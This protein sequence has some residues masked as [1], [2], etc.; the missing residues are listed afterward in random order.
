MKPLG[1]VKLIMIHCADTKSSMDVTRGDLWK[2]HV[3]DNGWDDIGYHYYIKFD[4]SVHNCRPITY[5]GA[6]CVAVNH[7]SLAICLEGGFGGEDNFTDIQKSSL[8]SLICNIKSGHPNAA[9]VGHNSI[10][11]KACPSFD[12]VEWYE[13]NIEMGGAIEWVNS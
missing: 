3:R 7:I 2:W 5:Q 8:W 1:D 6:H 11:D 9:V 12:V 10:D 13:N 4:G